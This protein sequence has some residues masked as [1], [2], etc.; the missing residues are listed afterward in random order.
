MKTFLTVILQDII[1][2]ILRGFVGFKTLKNRFFFVT[3][4]I[5]AQHVKNIFPKFQVNR[6]KILEERDF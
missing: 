4:Y 6:S 3:I 1:L 5:M 2:Q